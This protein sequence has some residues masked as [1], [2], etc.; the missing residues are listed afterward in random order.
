[1]EEE[2]FNIEAVVSQE[3]AIIEDEVEEV[4]ESKP[5]L[6]EMAQEELT[7]KYELEAEKEEEVK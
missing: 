6:E 3:E 1:M 4:L 5:R 7:E 2:L